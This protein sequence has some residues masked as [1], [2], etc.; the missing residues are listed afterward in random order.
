MYTGVD[1]PYPP[2]IASFYDGASDGVHNYSVDF[3]QNGGVYSMNADWGAP[4]L[5]FSVGA[6]FL[7]ITYDGSDNTLWLS[8]F[9]GNQVRHYSLGGTLLGS[10]TAAQSSLD[11][12]ALDPADG[13][14]WM[15]SQATEGT[16]YQYSKTGTLLGTQTYA[17]LGNQNT[18]GG[19]FAVVRVPEP[20]TLALVALALAGLGLRRRGNQ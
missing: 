17:S 12:L 7:G 9:S 14:L 8:Q 20:A 18:L 4:N 3:R 1:D 2:L 15:G 6:G 5:L 13:T 19:E 16:F 10:F 11:A